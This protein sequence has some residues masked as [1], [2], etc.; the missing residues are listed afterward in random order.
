MNKWSELFNIPFPDC[1][2]CGQCCRCASPST[3]ATELLKKAKTD[4]KFSRYFFSIF[5]PY[6][7]IEEAKKANLEI[8]ER[9]LKATKKP[10]SKVSSENIV[11]YYCR[12]I[13]A[14]NKCLI[15]EDRPELCRDYPDSP[16]LIFAKD[17]AYEEWSKQCKEKYNELQEELK[18]LKEYKKEIENLKCRQ[19]F[20]DLYRQIQRINNKDYNLALTLPS[21]SLVSPGTS[22]MKIF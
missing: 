1:R 9:S 5:I 17:C 6:K 18:M 20:V 3:A 7:S 15:H 12:Y 14:D 10:D 13:S 4:N 16:F 8:V 21:L 11:F 19:R 22:W 2:M